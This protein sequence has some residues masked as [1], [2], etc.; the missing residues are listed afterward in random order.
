MGAHSSGIRPPISF[1]SSRIELASCTFCSLPRFFCVIIRSSY[2]HV[3]ISARCRS[4]P[5]FVHPNLLCLLLAFFSNNSFAFF[6]ASCCFV[7]ILS[8]LSTTHHVL[9][10][11]GDV[12]PCSLGPVDRVSSVLFLTLCAQ[13]T[14]GLIASSCRS[15]P[16]VSS[17]HLHFRPFLSSDMYSRMLRCVWTLALQI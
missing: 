7:G 2:F 17:C 5:P 15:C 11:H 14:S 8:R 3:I 16:F 9:H 12:V 10:F 13:H 6:S 1:C 4:F